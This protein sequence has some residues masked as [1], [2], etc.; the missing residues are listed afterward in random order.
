M[1]AGV[2]QPGGQVV[3]RLPARNVVHEQRTGRTAVVR[4]GNGPESLLPSCVP[5]LQLNLEGCTL[6]QE[7]DRE[8]SK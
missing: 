1:L 2:L 3:E 8:Q 4:P 5:D 7:G 6:G